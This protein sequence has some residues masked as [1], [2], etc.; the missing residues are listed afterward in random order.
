MTRMIKIYSAAVLLVLTGIAVQASTI[1]EISDLRRGDLEIVGFELSKGA[2]VTIEAMGLRPSRSSELVVYAWIIESDSRDLVWEMTYR[3]TDRVRGDRSLRKLED[4]EF[5]EAGR[6]ELYM[7]Y[8]RNRISIFGNGVI[9]GLGKI[10][11]GD[12]DDDFWDDEDYDDALDEC[13]VRLSSEEVAAGDVESFEPD[14]SIK[15]S[16]IAHNKLG[17]SEYIRSGFKLDKPMDLHIYAVI[18]FP[19][20]NKYPVDN[21]WIIDVDSRDKIWEIDKWDTDPAGGGKKNVQF[22]DDVSF[23]AGNYV[24]HVVTDD[25]HSYEKF[26]VN[27]PY[28]PMN[29]GVT[30]LSGK[31]FDKSAFHLMEAPTRGEALIDLTRA[32]DGDFREQS[33]KLSEKTVLHVYSIGEY[34]SYSREFVDYGGIREIGSARPVWEMTKRNTEHAG[35]G[36]KNRMFDGTITLAAGTYTAFYMSDNSH[37]YRDWNTSA[38]YDPTAWGLAIYPAEGTKKSAFSLVSEEAIFEGS[39]ILARLTQVGDS[40][41]RRA[42]FTLKKEGYVHVYAVGEGDGG[43]MYDY[44]YI[45]D[46]DSGRDVWEMTFRRT[47]HAGGASKNRVFDDDIKLPSGNYEVVFV[48]DGSHSFNDWNSTPPRDPMNWG[49]TITADE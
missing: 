38:P 2:E 29:W 19:K 1:A 42:S 27:P 35:G 44:A 18:E 34:G 45:V 49:I 22:N 43:R 7:N 20:G 46:D 39:G 48:T 15:G 13:F 31:S 24:L 40:Q 9:S 26:N 37:S 30:I 47:D 23:P 36:D 5:L 6:Y 11:I 3:N 41:R 17:D 32:R 4:A 10:I 14:G 33:F 16:L 21:A 25:S 12:D 8:S 28:D